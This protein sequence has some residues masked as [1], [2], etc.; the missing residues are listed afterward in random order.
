MRQAVGLGVNTQLVDACVGAPSADQPNALLDAEKAGQASS[1][2]RGD[3]SL[4]PT[5]IANGVQFRGELDNTTVMEF[6]CAAYPA[7]GAPPQ[8]AARSV[9]SA[10]C[11]EGHYGAVMCATHGAPGGDGATRCSDTG[12]FPFWQC[13]CPYGSQMTDRGDGAPT[14]VVSN[15]CL[16]RAAGIALCTCPTCVCQVLPAGGAAPFRC[17]NVTVDECAGYNGGCWQGDLAGKHYTAC[18]PD[19]SAKRAAALAGID[20][21]SVRGYTCTC[22]RGFSGDGAA[23]CVDVNECEAASPAVCSGPHMRCL[24]APGSYTCACEA[25]FAMDVPSMTCV[26]TSASPGGGSSGGSKGV[27]G[28]AVF[29]IILLTFAAAAAAGYA[30]YRWRLKKCAAL[31]RVACVRAVCASR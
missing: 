28:G 22:P 23:A 5:L 11:E 16:T 3:I 19:L 1:G 15:A 26:P 10:P 6:L 31:Q 13:S 12:A 30:L 9:I 2:R 14:C 17:S 8:C 18:A 27:S 24:N 4:F 25:G 29:G 20:P 7:G 21:A